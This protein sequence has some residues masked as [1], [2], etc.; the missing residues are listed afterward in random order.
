MYEL[1]Q[2][3]D[4]RKLLEEKEWE[5]AYKLFEE[6]LAKVIRELL[7]GDGDNNNNNNKDKKEKKSSRKRRKR[8]GNRGDEET[9]TGQQ[10]GTTAGLGNQQ[11]QRRRAGIG[12]VVGHREKVM[13]WGFLPAHH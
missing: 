9:S 13:R 4:K 7:K 11:Q 8:G 5:N 3:M 12:V 6:M 1:R 2:Q 10:S